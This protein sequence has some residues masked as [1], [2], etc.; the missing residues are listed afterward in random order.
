MVTRWSTTTFTDGV[1]TVA[2]RGELDMSQADDLTAT[3]TGA[4]TR[5]DVAAI[6]VN[7]AEVTFL[8][9]T[10]IGSLIAGCN[11]AGDAGTVYRAVGAAGHVEKVLRVAGV[12]DLLQQPLSAS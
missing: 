12:L 10:V 6:E 8:D 7:L 9:S 1:C 2:L 4:A 11:A 5:A 3:L